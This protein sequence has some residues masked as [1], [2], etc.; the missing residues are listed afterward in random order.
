MTSIDIT[1]NVSFDKQQKMFFLSLVNH[2][3]HESVVLESVVLKY[4]VLKSVVLKSVCGSLDFRRRRV[5]VI[6]LDF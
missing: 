6:L 1:Q 4:V 2:I 3:V 5:S